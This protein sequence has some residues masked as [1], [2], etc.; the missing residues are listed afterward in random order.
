MS[1]PLV[2]RAFNYKSDDNIKACVHGLVFLLMGWKFI[3]D[4]HPESIWDMCRALRF[5]I[6]AQIKQRIEPLTTTQFLLISKDIQYN[7]GY[8]PEMGPVIYI[9][10]AHSNGVCTWGIPIFWPKSTDEQQRMV[11]LYKEHLNAEELQH[12]VDTRRQYPD[13]DQDQERGGMIM[14]DSVNLKSF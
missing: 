6:E 1:N 7:W 11:L 3:P 5:L 4:Y 2:P 8:H 10:L 13:L 9:Q 12:V 14:S